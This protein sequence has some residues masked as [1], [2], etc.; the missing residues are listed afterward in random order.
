MKQ[1]FTKS[2]A[3]EDKKEKKKGV[4]FSMYKYSARLSLRDQALFAKRLSLLSRSGVPILESI[5]ILSRQSKGSNKKMFDDIANDV[6]NGQFLSRSLGKFNRVFGEFAINI[7]RV[8]E[9]SGTL[10]DNLKYLAEET[11]KKR[12]LKGKV[13]GALVYPAV[14]LVA[15]IGIA[16]LLTLYLFPKLLPVFNSLHV[17][18]PITTRALIWVSTFLQNYELWV[19]LGLILSFIIF[20]ICLKFFR[21]FKKAFHWFLLK[22]PIIGPLFQNYYLTN[23]CRTMGLLM[24]GQ[25]HVLEAITVTAETSANLLYM[26]EL[27]ELKIAITKG[28]NIAKHME[29]T[30]KLFPGMMTEMIHIG[31]TT[32]NLADTLT[33]LAQIYEQELDEQ[34]KRLSS[35]IEPTMMIAMG[36]LVGMVAVSIITPIYEVTQHLNP[37]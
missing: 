1:L 37:R 30:P 12:E 36:L 19:I 11:D 9:T 27:T 17:D 34:T 28:S 4:G 29:K 33:Y 35:L 7:I 3:G 15:S 26:D 14:I 8:G 24:R 25:V 18:L 6:A 20:I 2:G 23:V 16:A 13:V 31:E 32:G 21:S 10:S 5:K 22:L